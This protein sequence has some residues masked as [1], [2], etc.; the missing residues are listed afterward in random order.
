MLIV[1]VALIREIYSYYVRMTII[2]QA[3]NTYVY[4]Y[5]PTTKRV[6]R[7]DFLSEFPVAIKNITIYFK[8]LCSTFSFLICFLPC[9]KFLIYYVRDCLVFLSYL[10]SQKPLNEVVLKRFLW[11]SYS[12]KEVSTTVF[13][14]QEQLRKFYTL[15]NVAPAPINKIINHGPRVLLVLTEIPTMDIY[16]IHGRL[17]TLQ[18][19]HLQCSKPLKMV[20]LVI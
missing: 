19:K 6:H 11:G 18:S 20:T 4:T 7:F 5:V 13:N 3:H 1:T 12:V 16:L 17:H 9:N 14:Y 2:F 10:F 8:F 15:L